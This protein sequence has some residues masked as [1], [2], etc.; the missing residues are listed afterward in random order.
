MASGRQR[1]MRM[2]KYGGRQL[3]LLS[4]QWHQAT[5]PHN[6]RRRMLLYKR[7]ILEVKLCIGLL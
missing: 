7:I 2:A 6:H 1:P 4:H 3:T 5:A